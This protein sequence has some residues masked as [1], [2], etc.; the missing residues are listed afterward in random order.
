MPLPPGGEFSRSSATASSVLPGLL[1]PTELEM[2]LWRK[3]RLPNGR[4]WVGEPERP[5]VV[6]DSRRLWFDCALAMALAMEEP[7]AGLFR[8]WLPGLFSGNESPEAMDARRWRE[9]VGGTEM[10]GVE[11]W[12]DMMIEE[13]GEMAE[14]LE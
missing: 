4:G 11:L 5:S 12:F 6:M 8:L 3:L 1:D 14:W 7:V 10:G 9:E 13:K 2:L